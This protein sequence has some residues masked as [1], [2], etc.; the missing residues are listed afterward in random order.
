VVAISPVTDLLALTEFANMANE[1]PARQLAANRIADQLAERNLWLTI[2][3]T[4]FRV[5]TWRTIEFSSRVIESA[6]ALGRR[7]S[8]ELH[9]GSSDGHHAP[10]GAYEAGAHWL[11]KRWSLPDP[12]SAH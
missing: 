2:G 3:T 1:Q 8:I 10:A 7:P 11:L 12:A 6:L 4:D 9:L 5:S